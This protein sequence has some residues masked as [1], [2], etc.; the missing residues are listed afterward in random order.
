MTIRFSFFYF[1]RQQQQKRKKYTGIKLT[2][3]IYDIS[4]LFDFEFCICIHYIRIRSQNAPRKKENSKSHSISLWH[5]E[6]NPTIYSICGCHKSC[7]LLYYYFLFD[8]NK[9]NMCMQ[10]IFRIEM[11]EKCNSNITKFYNFFF[12]CHFWLKKTLLVKFHLFFKLKFTNC[13]NKCFFFFFD[14]ISI[15]QWLEVV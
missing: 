14:F 12:R 1:Q 13:T 9:M 6:I 10:Y 7:C 8:S 2:K 11:T 4:I 3:I 15:I 5:L